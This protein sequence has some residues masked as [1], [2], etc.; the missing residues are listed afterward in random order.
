VSVLRMRHTEVKWLANLSR[1]KVNCLT[2]TPLS[3]LNRRS[4][5]AVVA[6]RCELSQVS[7][8]GR[9]CQT[10]QTWKPWR[11]FSRD[12][13]RSTGKTS[14]CIECSH[15]RTIK[16][17]YGINQIEWEWLYQSQGGLCALC[18]EMDLVSLAVDH[19]PM[20]LSLI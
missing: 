11:C 14:N 4:L 8:E 6:H 16:S 7:D 20:P 3:T 13:R 9:I 10:C 17:I 5:E 15:W 12:P 18:R 2:C 1:A 19:D